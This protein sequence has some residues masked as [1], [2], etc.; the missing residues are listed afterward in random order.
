MAQPPSQRQ[1]RVAE[2]IRKALSDV[3][4]RSEI[5]DPELDGKVITVPEVR[6][7]PDLKIAF[8]YIMPLGGEDAQVIIKA[9]ARNK[10]F[11]RGRI[12]R[13]VRLKYAPD[14][15]FLFD[16]TFDEYAK[17]DTILAQNAVRRDQRERQDANREADDDQDEDQH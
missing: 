12:S 17:I 9:L 11:L 1:L 6:M 13:M 16:D 3:L 10:K 5:N 2:L 8:A 7:T 15:R 14:L 4:A